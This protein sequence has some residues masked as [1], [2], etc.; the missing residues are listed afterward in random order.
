MAY[1]CHAISSFYPDSIDTSQFLRPSEFD[2]IERE[3]DSEDSAETSTALF[4][5]C[6][7]GSSSS[8]REA[9]CLLIS[10]FLFYSAVTRD[11]SSFTDDAGCSSATDLLF[12][13]S[14]EVEGC[15]ISYCLSP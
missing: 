13:T 1:C 14:T 12:D 11:F 9:L 4:S 2:L 5:T 8:F 6:W 10:G 15:Y 3:H 7:A